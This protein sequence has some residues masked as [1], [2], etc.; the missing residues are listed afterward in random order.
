MCIKNPRTNAIRKKG[1]S[2]AVAVAQRFFKRSNFTIIHESTNSNLNVPMNFLFCSHDASSGHWVP[3]GH[4]RLT[5][6]P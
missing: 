3:I 6:V 4:C 1:G 2:V 5:K